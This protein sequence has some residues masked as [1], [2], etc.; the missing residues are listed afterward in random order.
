MT[1]V[2]MSPIADAVS[3]N[4]HGAIITIEVTASS[5][6][7]TFPAGFNAWR[8]TIGCRVTSPAVEDRANKA[9]VALI[10]DALGLP[11]R[12]VRI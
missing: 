6:R 5:K 12:A 7:D 9:V 2:R 1:G 4:K 8:K 11:A 10:A 3:D